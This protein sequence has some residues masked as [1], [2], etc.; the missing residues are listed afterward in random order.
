MPPND[1][2]EGGEEARLGIYCEDGGE[3]RVRVISDEVVDGFRRVTVECLEVLRSS[4]LCI[5]PE[6]G[7]TWTATR[8]IDVPQC[9]LGWDLEEVNHDRT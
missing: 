7:E 1:T 3:Y 9:W 5:D 4:A 2:T 6:I 8:R